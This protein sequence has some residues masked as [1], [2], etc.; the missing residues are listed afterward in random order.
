MGSAVVLYDKDANALIICV[1]NVF[2]AITK[3]ASKRNEESAFTCILTI[4]DDVINLN[5]FY[6]MTFINNFKS[7][8]N[9]FY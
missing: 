4:V 7:I 2:V 5:V 1:P 6:I 8:Y 3:S 9:I